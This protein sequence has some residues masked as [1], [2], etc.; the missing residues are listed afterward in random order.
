[1]DTV[2]AST[3][4]C[5]Q[6]SIYND[7]VAFID[8]RGDPILI[9]PLSV[10][11]H[12]QVIRMYLD[13]EPRDSFAGLPPIRDE[14]CVKWVE[15]MIRE[16][17]NL[18]AVSF[19][20]GIIGHAALFPMDAERCEMFIVMSPGHQNA[21]IGTQLTRSIIQLAYE[22]EFD[23][24]WLS[25]E[26]KNRIA[27]HVYAKCGFEYMADGEIDERDMVLH[28]K[29]YHLVKGVSVADVMNRD[30]FSISEHTSCSGAIDV[31][32]KNHMGAL[33]V[34]DRDNRVVGILSE[35]DLITVGS[36][37]HRVCDVM[38][39]QVVSLRLD[40]SLSRVIRLFQSRRIRCLPVLDDEMR[41]VGVVGRK[42]LLAFYAKRFR[43]MRFT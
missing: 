21:G 28:L 30:V 39:R 42:D 24:I 2:R 1:M 23:R 8:K 12:G 15:G 10:K 5:E 11:R 36:C 31:F 6:T 25:V 9:K 19:E 35:T 33:P 17:I 43:D 32:V 13:Y 38:T 4:H 22:L 14:E 3:I 7:P 34:V 16:G 18:V 27:Q 29:R 41:L 20:E 26:I 37:A 40:S